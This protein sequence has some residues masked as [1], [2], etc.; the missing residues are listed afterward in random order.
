MDIKTGEIVLLSEW[1]IKNTKYLSSLEQEFN[2]LTK[3]KHH[4]LAHYL[5]F[6]YETNPDGT[7]VVHIL[8]EYVNGPNCSFFLN[9]NFN[10]SVQFIKYVSKGVLTA[11]D[12][13]HRNNVVHKDIRES[14]VYISEKGEYIFFCLKIL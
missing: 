3:L 10:V 11:L 13:L 7:V 12:Y 4:N 5:N 2:Y 9:E 6:K 14:C 1:T 8:K